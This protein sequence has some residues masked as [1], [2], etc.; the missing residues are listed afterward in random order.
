MSL[1]NFKNNKGS[2]TQYITT[3]NPTNI[4]GLFQTGLRL[5]IMRKIENKQ[6][7]FV[8]D[9]GAT[10]S[11]INFKDLP[12]NIEP[13]VIDNNIKLITAN[14][15]DLILLGIVKLKLEL[16]SII[17]PTRCIVVKNL[18]RPS[19]LG[20]DFLKLYDGL[21][22]FR[23]EQIQ[24]FNKENQISDFIPR[25]WKKRKKLSSLKITSYQNCL[26]FKLHIY[27]L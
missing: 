8:I 18:V 23:D 12:S 9:T 1:I 16:Q 19:L 14:G 4:S 7:F 25:N 3:C 11:I 27:K 24:L 21:I 17:F 26:I 6:H 13:T 10:A 15:S 2:V 22:N 20:T 5:T